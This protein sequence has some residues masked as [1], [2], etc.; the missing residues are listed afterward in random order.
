MSLSAKPT[1]TRTHD[2]LLAVEP[3]RMKYCEWLLAATTSHT[4]R[5]LVWFEADVHRRHG[6]HVPSVGDL[7][8]RLGSGQLE[9]IE[10]VF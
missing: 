8:A 3:Y 4:L 2:L 9:G 5:S 6:Y 10:D 7:P 1:N